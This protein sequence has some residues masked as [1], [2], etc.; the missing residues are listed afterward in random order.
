MSDEVYPV[1]TTT[2]KRIEMVQLLSLLRTDGIMPGD[3]ILHALRKADLERKNEAVTI[4]RAQYEAL[5]EAA[6]HGI[7]LAKAEEAYRSYHD[8]CGDGAIETG[9]A[10]DVMRRAGDKMRKSEAALRSAG[11]LTGE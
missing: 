1:Q 9:R 7:A 4:P 6:K 3:V 5:M 10:W 11:I 2:E 8:H